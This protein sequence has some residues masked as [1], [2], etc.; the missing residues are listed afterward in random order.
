M[1]SNYFWFFPLPQSLL[2]HLITAGGQM[3]YQLV[4]ADGT[5]PGPGAIFILVIGLA[6]FGA[7]RRRAS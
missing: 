3:V 2:L 6:G 5:V 7:M 1:L 4:F